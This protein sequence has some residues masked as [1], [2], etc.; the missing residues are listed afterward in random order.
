MLS[1]QKIYKLFEIKNTYYENI[2]FVL[3]MHDIAKSN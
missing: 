2:T 1:N 3:Q